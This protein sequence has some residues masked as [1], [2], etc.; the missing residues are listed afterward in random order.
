MGAIASKHANRRETMDEPYLREKY[1][2]STI[3]LQY[4]NLN[5]FRNKRVIIS[6]KSFGNVGFNVCTASFFIWVFV[7]LFCFVF[8]FA[9]A[10]RIKTNKVVIRTGV[11]NQ[12]IFFPSHL[13]T[14]I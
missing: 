9:V 8:S 13:L 11:F 5:S 14:S 2:L 3:L 12:A 4:I 6:N 7:F 1:L 10:K